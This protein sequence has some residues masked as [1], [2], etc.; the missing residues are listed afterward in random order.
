M[1]R[2]YLDVLSADLSDIT[3]LTSAQSLSAALAKTANSRL[4]ALEKAGFTSSPA[5]QRA[6]YFTQ[7]IR[8]GLRFS[9]SKNLSPAMLQK[10]LAELQ[11]FLSNDASL[12]SNEKYRRAGLNKIMPNATRSEKQ[13]M[14]RF[15]ESAAFEELKKQYGGTDI[16]KRG[17]DAIEQGAKVAD[18]NRLFRDFQRREAAGQNTVNEDLYSGVWSKWLGEE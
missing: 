10:Q 14:M 12:P 11:A 13:A 15:L 4:R 2:N 8:D 7:E 18:L 17:S 3:A 6:T 16:V 1:I 5:Y 9:Q